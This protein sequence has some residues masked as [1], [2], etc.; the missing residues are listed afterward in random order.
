MTS[1]CRGITCKSIPGSP[2]PS[3]SIFRRGEGRA[4]EQG[5]FQPAQHQSLILARQLLQSCPERQIPPSLRCLLQTRYYCTL[6]NHAWWPI[7]E[8]EIFIP[9]YYTIRRDRN[10]RD[11]G[12]LLYVNVRIPIASIQCHH[13]GNMAVS[14]FCKFKHSF[15]RSMSSLLLFL[16]L[17]ILSLS[18]IIMLFFQW[19]VRPLFPNPTLL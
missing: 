5:Y 1:S 8:C 16:L 15:L 6:R 3:F 13:F 19:A 4:W 14:A 12:V 17:H 7:T 11:G 9:D 10:R 2:P 18:S